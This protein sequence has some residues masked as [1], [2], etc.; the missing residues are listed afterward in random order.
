MIVT[1]EYVVGIL[2]GREKS[3]KVGQTGGLSHGGKTSVL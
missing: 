1:R 3:K 2:R